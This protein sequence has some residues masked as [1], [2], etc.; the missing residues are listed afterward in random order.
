M[1]AKLDGNSLL[2]V[3][4][5]VDDTAGNPVSNFAAVEY[6]LS[7]VVAAGVEGGGAQ[8]A[9][10]ADS[11]A[12]DVATLVTDFNALLTKLKAAGLMASS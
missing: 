9:F 10:Q 12:A 8:A 3:K 5:I 11:V 6:K 7:E 4:V 2:L 1:S